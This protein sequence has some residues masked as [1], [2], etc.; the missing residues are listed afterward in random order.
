MFSIVLFF[1]NLPRAGFISL[2]LVTFI[3]VLANTA[4]FAV[5]SPTEI[6]SSNAVAVVSTKFFVKIVSNICRRKIQINE[7]FLL[8]L[9]SICIFF[10]F[11]VP[12]NSVIFSAI[13]HEGFWKVSI[14]LQTF[15]D[16][17]LG[18]MSWIMPLSV[19]MSTF[20]WLNGSIFGSAR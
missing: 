15:G 13:T 4:Y 8:W 20:G 10:S 5:L 1:R 3:Y 19:A 7:N 16:R 6:L 14:F 2:A 18:V 12:E 9:Q 17:T 11:C